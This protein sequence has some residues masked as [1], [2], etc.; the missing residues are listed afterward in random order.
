MNTDEFLSAVV[1]A[2]KG[3]FVLASRNH[4]IPWAQEWY[5]WP[6]DVAKVSQRANF[7][8]ATHDVYFTSYLFDAQAATKD[9]SLPTQTIQA[10]LDYAD[11]SKLP[12][13]PSIIVQT[14]PQRYQAYWLLKYAV[15]KLSHEALSKRVTYAI[16]AADR[17]GWTVGH[18]LRLP[19]T[20][21]HKYNNGPH[22]ILVVSAPMHV[23]APEDIE[24]LPDV[25]DTTELLA[26][27]SNTFLDT[28][29]AHTANATAT[30]ANGANG[31][32]VDC[33]II[34]ENNTGPYDLIESIKDRIPLAVY[35]AFYSSQPA[36][37]R[38]ST[39]WA[40]MTA[41]FQAGLTREKVFF[42]A[43][44]SSNNKF[45]LDQHYHADI[46]LAKDVV[47]AERHAKKKTFDVKGMVDA[48]R[49]MKKISHFGKN[50]AIYQVVH[51][52]MK[53]EGD[54]IRTTS[55]PS[56]Y[57][58]RET[59]R[60]LA[61]IHNSEQL[62]SLLFIK[63]GLNSAEDVQ[64]Y[65]IDALINEHVNMAET[66]RV[67][68]M[69]YYSTDDNALYMH[70]GRKEVLKI[71]A[72]S[73]TT[74]RNGLGG[75]LFPWDYLCEPF[76]PLFP[77]DHPDTAN[78]SNGEKTVLPQG[79]LRIED[80]AVAQPPE[81]TTAGQASTQ[82]AIT[83]DWGWMVFGPLQNV[84]NMTPDEARTLLKVWFIFLLMRHG[85]AAR[86]ILAFFGSQGSGKTSIMRRIYTMLYAK[87]LR[88]SGVTTAA[89]FD[90][91]ASKLPF[92]C[93]DNAD[94]FTPWLPSKLAQATGDV[95]DVT[96]KYFTNLDSVIVHRQSMV[97]V[98]AHNP[99][100]TREDVVDRLLM[101]SFNR[102]PE[103]DYVA[104]QP[105][106]DEIIKNR[107]ILWGMILTD[108]RHVL[109]TRPP[110]GSQ[111]HWRVEDFARLG[112]WIANGIGPGVLA[113]FQ[114]ALKSF[115]SSQTSLLLQEDEALV[116]CLQAY[117]DK[118]GG[119]NNEYLT[120]SNLW[121]EV[122]LTCPE[123]LVSQMQRMYKNP[124]A[125]GKKLFIMYHVINSVFDVR[126]KQ[127][128]QSRSWF[129][130]KRV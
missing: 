34:L 62:N 52:A 25:P 74:Q 11:V 113:T 71:T 22:D 16:E 66:A 72:N 5:T 29:L 92:Y 44:H 7:L 24:L 48:W 54:F 57:I 69:S 67:V 14:S 98:T 99:K 84:S 17:T 119:T 91:T 2:E 121:T 51:D 117:V 80:A 9:A 106:Y 118:H 100:F 78:H 110:D 35:S 32:N 60:P 83:Q 114:S 31:L 112:E 85:A 93:I 97:G 10:D 129:I 41:G 18:R 126:F 102:I 43:W 108:V 111:V 68:V 20:L 101:L 107:N 21:N 128:P 13:Q 87:R 115:I 8:R 46:D 36:P 127:G 3:N 40:L 109:R 12:L 82:Q 47:R 58:P 61:L 123:Q 70:T 73:I 49:V 38:S 90:H 15:D 42:L 64:G 88:I 103:D 79:G 19:N 37:D 81:L 50:R 124:T 122:L 53:L 33:P 65:V 1:T 63:F 104:E 45:K 76:T 86:P 56:W 28:L 105:I 39:L 30:L 75:F 116:T 4:S 23:Y 89:D 94:E 130:G 95:D 125:F 59:G 27:E 96:R 6:D 120:P 26:T 55:G 77:P